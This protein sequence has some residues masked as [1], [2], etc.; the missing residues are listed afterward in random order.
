VNFGDR[1]A[2]NFGIHIT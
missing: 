1:L 2:V